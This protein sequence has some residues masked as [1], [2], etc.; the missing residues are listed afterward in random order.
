MDFSGGRRV[1][2]RNNIKMEMEAGRAL[3]GKEHLPFN[4]CERGFV[5]NDKEVAG[6]AAQWSR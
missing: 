3:K 5:Q 2:D 4:T 1:L 6:K